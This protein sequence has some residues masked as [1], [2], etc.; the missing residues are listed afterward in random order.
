MRMTV[1]LKSAD[2][3]R[4]MKTTVDIDESRLQIP[5]GE[6]IGLS[7]GKVENEIRSTLGLGPKEVK[8]KVEPKKEEPKVEVKVEQPAPPLA[9]AKGPVVGQP[10]EKPAEKP[11]EAPA[12]PAA[13]EAPK[14]GGN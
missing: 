13:T 10:A 2:G 5:L 11:V 8:K 14:S 3:K 12:A 4:D 9:E 6:V 1:D 7:L